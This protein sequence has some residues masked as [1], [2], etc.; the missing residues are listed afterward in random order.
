MRSLGARTAGAVVARA[1]QEVLADITP[2]ADEVADARARAKR[3]QTRLEKSFY[4]TDVRVVGSFVKRTA[5][6]RQSDLDLFVCL[7]R[8]EARWGGQIVNSRTFLRRVQ[9]ALQ[10]LYPSSDLRPDGQAVTLRFNSGV[11]RVDRF[12]VVPAVLDRI[13]RGGAVYAIPDGQGGWMQT[14]PHLQRSYLKAASDRSGGKLP[15][16]VQLVK[17]WTGVRTAS[18]PLKPF[19]VEMVLAGTDLGV[20]AASYSRLA[21]AAFELLARRKGRALRDPMGVSGL[22]PAADTDAKKEKVTAALERAAEWASAAVDAEERGDARGAL[23]HWDR[24]FNRKF[25]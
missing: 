25:R 15:R 11:D 20:G 19:H 17:W 23:S 14:A 18:V 6:W 13:E 16:V 5:V 22:L 1:F 24:V 10:T 7:A 12:D 2:R 8:D 9:T 4:V 21:A 3:I